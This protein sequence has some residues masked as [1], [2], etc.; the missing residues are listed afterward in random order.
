MQSLEQHSQAKAQE[1]IQSLEYCYVHATS[2]D[3]QKIRGIE[4]PQH[5]K[6]QLQL[7]LSQVE[8][9]DES[10]YKE[11]LEMVRK[12]KISDLLIFLRNNQ[13]LKHLNEKV[14]RKIQKITNQK[15]RGK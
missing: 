13:N 9:L 10:L 11:I 14:K 5:D 15:P 8:D 7:I 6:G 12:E 1:L 4:E 3:L 2:D